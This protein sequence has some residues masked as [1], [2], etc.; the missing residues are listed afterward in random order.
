MKLS[1]VIKEMPYLH[2]GKM[3]PHVSLNSY[4]LKTIQREFSLL[5]SITMNGRQLNVLLRND[6]TAVIGI[7]DD[8]DMTDRFNIE[9]RLLFK[10]Q[11][12]LNH[13]P[14][15]IANCSIM[16]V[17]KVTA[18]T[19]TIDQGLAS[20]VYEKLVSLGRAVVSDN[21]HFD[22]GAALWKKLAQVPS[23]RVIVA[24][25]D[26][27]TFKDAT[28]QTIQYNGSNIP[29]ASIWTNGSDYSGQY[30]VLILY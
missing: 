29:D 1:E 20:T 17:D 25:V 10:P 14:P 16:Q 15:E 7:F 12:E 23:N 2:A 4:S 5:T 8:Q 11:H 22:P 24:D 9:F 28:G 3:P 27:G 6:H 21:T 13:V 19:P 26:T 18:S 30:R